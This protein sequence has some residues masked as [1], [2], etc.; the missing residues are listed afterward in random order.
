VWPGFQAAEATT[1]GARPSRTL[2]RAATTTVSTTGSV[3][4]TSCARC[5]AAHPCKKNARVGH[6]PSQWCNA[7][8]GPPALGIL[9]TKCSLGRTDLLLLAGLFAFRNQGP[10]FGTVGHFVCVGGH[11]RVNGL[12]CEATVSDLPIV[13]PCPGVAVNRSAGIRF[14]RCSASQNKCK[15]FHVSRSP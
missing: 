11:V 7:K 4:R 14:R 2:R 9:G 1:A 15:S 3:E 13:Y 12:L 8:D 10:G 6:P 5:I